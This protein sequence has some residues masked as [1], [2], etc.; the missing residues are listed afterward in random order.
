MGPRETLEASLTCSAQNA[1]RAQAERGRKEPAL[2]S[3]AEFHHFDNQVAGNVFQMNARARGSRGVEPVL[4]FIPAGAG[5]G[6]IHWHSALRGS[7][8]PYQRRGGGIS[9][10]Y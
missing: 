8:H 3:L 9:A 10:A 2:L 7:V 5:N 4:A 6:L 1:P